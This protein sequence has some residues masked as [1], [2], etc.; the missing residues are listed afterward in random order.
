MKQ[1]LTDIQTGEYAKSFIIEKQV[2]ALTLYRVTPDGRAPDR[3]GRRQAACDDAVD[4]GK[5]A[6]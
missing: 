5:Q 3:N 2:L 4:C 1:V 6:G